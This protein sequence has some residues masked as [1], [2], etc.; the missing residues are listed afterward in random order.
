MKKI[1]TALPR[2]DEINGAQKLCEIINKFSSPIDISQGHFMIDGKSLLGILSIS[3][4]E[5]MVLLIH[6]DEITESLI[7]QL[8]SNN[9]FAAQKD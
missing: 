4:Q 2:H 7:T 8:K 3:L 6:D 1:I 5:P 9:I